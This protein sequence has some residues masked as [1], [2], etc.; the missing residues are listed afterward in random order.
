MEKQ[1]SQSWVRDNNEDYLPWVAGYT[2]SQLVDLNASGSSG[3]RQLADLYSTSTNAD[4]YVSAV[5]AVI[6]PV[7]IHRKIIA[8]VWEASVIDLFGESAV[9]EE[10]IRTTAEKLDFIKDSFGISL[11]QLA[12]ILCTTRPSVY[13]WL[14][15][16][17]P[18]EATSMRIQQINECTEYWAEINQFHYRP[19]P[20][21]RQPLGRKPSVLE[22]FMK[23][24]LDIEEIKVGL[25]IMMDLMIRRRERIDRSKEETKNTTMDQLEI[26]KNRHSLTRTTGHID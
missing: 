11:S 23:K 2:P 15:G 5:D 6:H 26:D 16:E 22:R 17:E 25:N 20:L 7:N 4:W 14:E 10:Q 8:S 1:T 13:S 18:R 24:E 3:F 19:G 21:F 9:V 12:K